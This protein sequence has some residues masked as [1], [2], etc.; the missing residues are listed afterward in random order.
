MIRSNF[1]AVLDTCV[2]LPMPWADTLLR[3]AEE[4]RLYVPKWS[5]GILVELERNLVDKL[6]RKP[7]QA[8]K[9]IAV[10][11]AAF[12]D[13][14]VAGYEGVA[15]CMRNHEKDRHVLACAVVAGA[16]VIVTHD[17][18]DFPADAL[19]PFG[20]HAEA[21]DEFLICAY[22]LDP[23][24]AM[25]KLTRQA[26]AIGLTVAEV[27]ERLRRSAPGFVHY[28][29]ADSGLEISGSRGGT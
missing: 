9:R 19:A 24:A 28:V 8:R 2:L 25:Y 14:E 13:A 17:L 15:R 1:K 6:G 11:R 20:I 27:L 23:G 18:R 7:E 5:S 29:I 21:P 16:T 26:E 4:P 12:P 10:M 3:F 22:D